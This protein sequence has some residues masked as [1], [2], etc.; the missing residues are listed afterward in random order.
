MTATV[1][2]GVIG[3]NFHNET[4]DG[5]EIIFFFFDTHPTVKFRYENVRFGTPD[6]D[7]M[8]PV[9]FD[10]D[11]SHLKEV[12]ELQLGEDFYD[13][14]KG[15]LVHLLQQADNRA[16]DIINEPEIK[17]LTT[18]DS[19]AIMPL[20]GQDETGQKDTRQEETRQDK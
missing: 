3:F 20:T 11:I 19:P 9:M 13:Q 16:A 5:H 14:V 2:Q 18:H 12:D 10:L 8:V 4:K 15:L 6:E 17:S 1:E 7:N